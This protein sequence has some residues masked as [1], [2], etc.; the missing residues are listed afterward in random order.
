MMLRKL[1]SRMLDAA[2]G[3][4]V[5]GTASNGEEALEQIEK[6]RPDIVTLDIQ[7]PKLD[8]IGVLRAAPKRFGTDAPA[9]LVCSSLTKAG[10]DESLLAMRLGAADFIAKDTAQVSI[11]NGSFQKDLV[12]KIRAIVAG[13][14]RR[15]TSAI[16]PVAARSV[17][18][19]AFV[20]P[21]RLRLAVI[22][23][24]TG[25]PPVLE[26]LVSSLP[27]QTRAG[28]VI[29]Q[30]MPA[31]FTQSLA[32]RLD[33]VC[34]V[35]VKLAEQGERVQPSTV[36]I[37][38]GGKHVRVRRMGTQLILDVSGEPEHA[39][40]KPSVNEL[41]SSAAKAVGSGVL[42]I[43]VTGMGDDGRVGAAEIKKSGGVVIAQDETTSVVWGMPR[44]VTDDGTAVANFDPAGLA[45]SLVCSQQLGGGGSAGGD[46]A[47]R[48]S[49]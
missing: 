39:L 49:A 15:R 8:G 22:G 5:V 34:K 42:G 41:F 44:A 35:R 18:P 36:Y 43:V 47:S 40:Y 33:R 11:Q 37:G 21:D 20:A 26:T 19:E 45:A 17:K 32:E 23:S 13:H 9:F 6:L 31:V 10:S 4:D 16:Q 46:W 27:A 29:A 28:I 7:M 25:G 24:S 12:A 30:H 14:R 2:E 38:E 1:L 48:R 3:V